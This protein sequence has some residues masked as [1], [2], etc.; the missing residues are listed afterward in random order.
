MVSQYGYGLFESYTPRDFPAI[1]TTSSKNL[2]SEFNTLPFFTVLSNEKIHIGLLESDMGL[3]TALRR[4]V[5]V[6]C[7][8]ALIEKLW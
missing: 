3:K 2:Y 5:P 1:A 6:Y 8:S 4:S 7:S